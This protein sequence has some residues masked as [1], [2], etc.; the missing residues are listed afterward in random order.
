MRTMHV[1]RESRVFFCLMAVACML[2][3]LATGL[4]LSQEQRSGARRGATEEEPRW[5]T[6]ARERYDGT[7]HKTFHSRT[8]NGPVSYLIYLPPDYERDTTKRY[9][10]LYWLHG[11]S[12][13][14]ESGGAFVKLLDT[15]IR[16]NKAPSTIAVLVNGLKSMYNDSLDGKQ[17][18]ESV[19]IK[20]LIPHVDETYRT[21]S[22]REARWIEGFSMGGY[23]AAHL[24]FK[25]PE[26]F[27][28]VSNL[29]G[30]LQQWEFFAKLGERGAKQQG[31]E[32]QSRRR[33]GPNIAQEVFGG[34]KEYFLENHPFAVVE[35][36]ADI[37][38]RGTLGRIIAGDADRR[39][40]KV[41]QDFHALLDR[42]KIPHD[43]I[44]VPG[45]GHS[46]QKLYEV[47]SN[48]RAFEFFRKAFE[49]LN[50]DST[51]P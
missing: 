42:L 13:R 30:A 35:K 45:V 8:I 39:S 14:M 23:G 36:N 16:V 17:P 20:D 43:F 46:Y 34:E 26:L 40:F 24:G 44:A 37:I 32:Q 29:S 22:S 28:A 51:R 6:P 31:A 33:R 38:R 15:A 7:H 47:L 27:G 25:Y 48:D 3:L 19:T 41:S 12:G 49:R 10:V 4:A 2:I 11:G 5:V 21:L 9:P 18:V 1:A 50:R